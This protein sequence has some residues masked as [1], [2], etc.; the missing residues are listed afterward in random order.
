VTVVLA[1]LVLRERL[2]RHQ[3]IGVIG[4]LAGVALIAAR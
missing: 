2:A 1:Y 4:A 3:M